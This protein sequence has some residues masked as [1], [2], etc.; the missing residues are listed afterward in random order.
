MMDSI[1]CDLFTIKI[2][3][4]CNKISHLGL[5]Y[6]EIVNVKIYVNQTGAMLENPCRLADLVTSSP[7]VLNPPWYSL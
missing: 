1:V 2:Q 3:F 6:L 5:G 4:Q 7:G